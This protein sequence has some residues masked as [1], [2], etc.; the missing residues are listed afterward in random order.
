[1]SGSC[2]SVMRSGELYGPTETT[3]GICS[4]DTRSR[5]V[6]AAQ[7]VL[8]LGRPFPNARV[9]VLGQQLH[10]GGPQVSA[11]YMRLPD[12][13]RE[14]FLYDVYEN[15][16]ARSMYNSGDCGALQRS[17]EVEYRGRAD[18]QVKISGQRVEI[19]A[20]ESAV[21]S[22]GGVA[23]CVVT[24]VERGAGLLSLAAFVVL[25]ADATAAQRHN[26]EARIRAEVATRVARH[27]VPHQVV[28]VE[29]IR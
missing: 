16:G 23:S 21:A 4:L 1:M 5:P 15:D 6:D 9:Y 10:F 29:R 17:G 19:G 24:A 22:C 12:K 27:E 20:V 28:V 11:G 8:H 2:Q 14:K 3:I 18:D 26:V 13:T 25:A 7:K